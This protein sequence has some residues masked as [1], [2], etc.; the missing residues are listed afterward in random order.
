MYRTLLYLVFSLGAALVSCSPQE[1]KFSPSTDEPY[2]PSYHFSPAKGWMN[3]PNGLVYLDGEYH[4]FFQHYPDSTV[5][6]PMHWG[7]AV[8]KD[9]LN[10]E[11]LPIALFPDSLGYI[12]SGSAVYDEKNSSGLGS[13]AAPPLVA[14][15]TYHD[16]KGEKE[17]RK[18]Y[19]S[20]GLAYSLDK[21]RNWTKYAGN[22]VLPNQGIADFRDPK[23]SQITTAG[24]SQTWLM[25]LAARDRVQFYQSTNL[26]DWSLLGEFGQGVGA[27]GGVWECPELLSMKAP[28]GNQKWVLLVSINPGGPQKG[29]ATQY[30]IGDFDKGT[31][32][33]DDTMLRWLDYGPD[34][35]AGVTWANLPAEQNRKL[36]IGWMSNWLYGQVV[37]TP[38]WRSALTLPR[39]LSLFDVDG[40]LLLKSTPAKEVDALKSTSYSL[41][42]K[43][44]L[45]PSAAVE[46]LAEVSG[47]DSFSLLLSNE[48]G[49]EVAINKEMGLVTVDRRKAGKAAFNPDF[50]A[51]HAAP[52]SWKAKTL[53][54]FL[55]AS[56]LEL[57]VNEGELVI[58]SLLFPSSP[59]KKLTI[60]QGLNEVE[61]IS[62]K[63]P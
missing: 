28:D 57:F 17:G 53:R 26:K 33:P 14:L 3:D 52:M 15:F 20:Q 4:L 31:F 45:L 22:P 2:R 21:G 51:A 18:D 50:A 59:W 25:T 12:F 10:W 27:H 58:T 35:Y 36:F 39:E 11:E 55:D 60:Q 62:L 34:N 42:G 24:G 37:P 48:L 32:T 8:S 41:S 56:S 44:S 38:T 5:W 46:I 29:S 19:Q 30:F 61:I 13:E 47:E 9:L 16:P 49:E 1:I 6:G 40:T 43:E 23:I 7:H 54:I 63:K